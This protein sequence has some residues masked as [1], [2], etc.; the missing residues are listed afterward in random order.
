METYILY[1]FGTFETHEDVEYFIGKVLPE[2]PVITHISY[3]IEC[4]ESLIVIFQSDMDDEIKIISELPNYVINDYVK[5]YFLHRLKDMMTAYLPPEL[6]EMIFKPNN[7]KNEELISPIYSL[8]YLDEILEKIE[9]SGIESLNDKE[10]KF[11][12]DF[13]KTNN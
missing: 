13:N 4:S 11:L 7:E 6:N 10:K 2:C 3:V 8:T 1:V 5:F 12:D 9:T